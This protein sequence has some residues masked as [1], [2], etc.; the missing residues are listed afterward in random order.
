M[1]HYDIQQSHNPLKSLLTRS[2]WTLTRPAIVKDNLF[3]CI[4]LSDDLA[5]ANILRND[6]WNTSS[7]CGK[8][9]IKAAEAKADSS[10]LKVVLANLLQSDRSKYTQLFLD[11]IE[12]NQL[13]TVEILIDQ[14]RVSIPG[15]DVGIL[16]AAVEFERKEIVEKLIAGS[17]EPLNAQVIALQYA[18]DVQKNRIA[19]ELSRFSQT[20]LDRLSDQ[21]KQIL[22]LAVERAVPEVIPDLVARVH[23]K[24]FEKD[25]L[26][27]SAVN[28][29]NR[30]V[31]RALCRAIDDQ[32]V[33]Q[34][35]LSRVLSLNDL[36]S[37]IVFINEETN[38]S[39]EVLSRSSYHQDVVTKSFITAVESI[40]AFESE[41]NPKKALFEKLGYPTIPNIKTD[42]FSTDLKW[43]Q[44]PFV[45]CCMYA[46]A[47][48]ATLAM[49]NMDK[50]E[51]IMHSLISQ[52]IHRIS[53]TKGLSW[54][55]YLDSLHQQPGFIQDFR[56]VIYEVAEVITF[57][58]L[59]R[60]AMIEEGGAPA[61]IEP[62]LI[63]A[64]G[65]ASQMVLIGK[66]TLDIQVM[67]GKWHRGG[68][69]IPDEIRPISIWK[70]DGWIPLFNGTVALGPAVHIT[71]LTTPN[72]LEMEGNSMGHCVGSYSAA[73]RGGT[74][75]ILS[76]RENN[77]AIGT[78]ELN[79]APAGEITPPNGPHWRVRQFRGYK[80]SAPEPTAKVA[81]EKFK[82]LVRE[83]KVVFNRETGLNA[84]E[85]DDVKRL[86]EVTRITRFD[87]NRSNLVRRAALKHYRERVSVERSQTQNVALISDNAEKELQ[88][89]IASLP[90]QTQ[91]NIVPDVPWL[92]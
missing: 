59:V 10:C 55:R 8:E 11:A 26:F 83:G 45:Q 66:S 82:I 2:R 19:R 7:N 13:S 4:E 50:L 38:L 43:A 16:K 61:K 31:F 12:A 1:S 71:C 69:R 60:Q 80:N 41:A 58:I 73:C 25:K 21:F 23:L 37:A 20:R 49:G 89:W 85:L 22:L 79:R 88:N 32:A 75:Q 57:P 67:N 17:Y 46:A 9:L 74:S 18:V 62:L 56:D 78:I 76:I 40:Y 86:D 84:K 92:E 53:N 44:Q 52:D 68:N 15:G 51:R 63:K 42:A 90:G 65:L 91:T 87:L 48:A 3:R 29:P 5:L 64:R 35:A 24:D 14:C 28:F 36:E 34:D 72:E 30:A 39:E 81:F 27:L 33:R 47:A 6:P 77:V 70:N 54:K